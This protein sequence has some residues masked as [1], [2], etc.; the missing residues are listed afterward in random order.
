MD[1]VFLYIYYKIKM[2]IKFGR[3]NLTMRD[4]AIL[5][6]LRHKEPDTCNFGDDSELH[7]LCYH[8]NLK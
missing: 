5:Y 3:M 1:L 6:R 7:N 4:L 8:Y 2:N